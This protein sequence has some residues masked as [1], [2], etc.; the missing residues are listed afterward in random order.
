MAK[1]LPILN[2][3]TRVL[4]GLV[5]LTALVLNLSMA[6]IMFAPDTLPK[7]FY[8][9]YQDPN[10]NTPIIQTGSPAAIAQQPVATA[11][12][13]VKP[14]EGVMLNTGTKIVNLSETTGSKYIRVT[15]VLEF[16]PKD[17]TYT[18]MEAA[19]KLTYLTAFTD[20][21]NTKLPMIDDTIITLL[22]TKTFNDLYTAAGKEALRQ[23]LLA[24]VQAQ[25]PD[26][27][28]MS[29]YFTEFVVD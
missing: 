21:L 14:G 25:M 26:Y 17:P 4:L 13:A 22:S 20:E 19:A 8:L 23:E 29:V 3:V 1:I 2:I 9:M 27:Q 16:A 6:Y 24:K 28:L 12:P 15:I 7:P 11:A 18:T 10:G 5:L